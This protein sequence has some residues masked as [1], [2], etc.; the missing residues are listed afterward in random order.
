MPKIVFI[1]GLWNK[2]KEEYIINNS[3]GNIQNAANV[4]QWN[5]I[6]GLDA[7]S[8]GGVDILSSFF[9]GSFP[10]RFKKFFISSEQFNHLENESHKDFYVGFLNLPIIKHFSRAKRIIRQFKKS[11]Y[12]CDKPIYVIGYSMTL[13]T[14]LSLKNI[15]KNFPFSKT[16]LVVPD[17]P[18]YMN[19]GKRQMMTSIIKKFYTKKLYQDIK[20]ID[21]FVVLTE[22]IYQA[23][24]VSNKRHCVIEGVCSDNYKLP[25]EK[26]YTI[27]TIFYSGGLCEKYGINDLVDAFFKIA[28]KNVRLVLCGDG[29]SV[30]YIKL[31]MEKDSRIV[32]LGLISNDRV[33]ELQRQAFLLIN[34]RKPDEDFTKYSFPSKTIEYM[35]S[36][37][38]VLMYKLDCIPNEYDDYLI[39]IENG[40]SESINRVLMTDECKL[41]ELGEK[42][43]NFIL[44]NKN[45][46]AQAKKILNMFELSVNE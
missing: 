24:G 14:V 11:K 15:K 34:P 6:S 27:R 17:L 21:S 33:L 5:M 9:I 23:L 36:G 45:S 39:Y 7:F 46:I 35:I 29:D 1:G 10:F 43:R 19:T 13:S 20:S 41:D 22:P 8:T 37:R 32:Y 2:S 16:C 4:F 40:L 26:F 30:K 3:I 28:D 12:Q 44:C 38:P 18:E 31:A 25:K 42:A